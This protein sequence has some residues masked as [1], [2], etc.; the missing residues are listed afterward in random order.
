MPTT[1]VLHTNGAPNSVA[2]LYPFLTSHPTVHIYPHFQVA[3]DGVVEQYCPL[4]RVAWAQYDGNPYAISVETQD[5]GSATKAIDGDP[6]S[7]A[8]LHAIA[9]LAIRL[10]VGAKSCTNVFSGGV[11]YHSQFTAEWNRDHHNCP[12]KARVAQI[13]KIIEY[14]QP[15]VVI[16]STTAEEDMRL[17]RDP[18]SGEI[19]VL[20]G[21]WRGPVVA[22][23]IT[24]VPRRLAV[25]AEWEQLLGVV[26]KDVSADFWDSLLVANN[27]TGPTHIALSG[28]LS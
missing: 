7:E 17:I 18:R 25:A 13:P 14:M 19:D 11:G 5:S 15:N 24:D 21:R 9:I 28:T 8:Q 2:S 27:L 10:G 3:W 23:S 16:G 26:A 1:L 20:V 22:D 6:W 4:E 12:G